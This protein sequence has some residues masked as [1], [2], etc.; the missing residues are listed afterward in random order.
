MNALVS[1]NLFR[2]YSVGQHGE[3][4]LSH[5]QFAD[6]T[7]I[8]G[9]KT[10][11]NVCSMQVVL[12]LFEDISRLKVNFNKSMLTGVNVSVSWLSE[13]ASVMNCRMGSIPF[14]YLGLPIGGDVKKIT[15]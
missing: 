9:E 1:N 14:V 8:I 4:L 5:L 10:W 6:G 13:A 7:I 2:G 12:L 11:S 15:F 3:V